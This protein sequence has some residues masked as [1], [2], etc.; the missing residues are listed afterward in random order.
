MRFRIGTMVIRSSSLHMLLA[1]AL[2]KV[3][4]HARFHSAEAES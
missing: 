1:E 2:E 4:L 3:E